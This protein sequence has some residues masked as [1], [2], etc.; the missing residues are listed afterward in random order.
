MSGDYSRKRFN[1][2]KHYQGVLRQ[3][4]RVDL[5]ADWNEY[6]DLQDRRWRAETIDVIGRC[7]VPSETPDGFKIEGTVNNLTVG[8][9]RI[10]VDGFLAENHGTN[11]QFNSTLEEKYGTAPIPVNDQPYGAGRSDG[12]GA[13]A[14]AGVSRCLAPRGHSSAGARLIEP[15]VNVDTTTRY[16]TAWQ[17]K[18]LAKIAADVTCKTPLTEIANWPAAN[19][20][21]AA[22]LTT[23]TVAV[24]HRARSLLG[25]AQRRLSRFGKSSLPRR[26]ARCYEQRP[27][28]S[29][30]WSRENAH[31]ATNVLEILPGRKGVRG[32]KPRTRRCLALQDRRLGGDH[33]RQPR[34]R[35]QARR[36]A[37]G[38]GRRYQSDADV[39]RRFADS[40]FPAGPA[41]AA[42]H[43]RVIRWDQSGSVRKP[44]GSELINLDLTNDGLILLTAANPSFVLEHGIQVTL[45]MTA[46]ARL[47]AATTGASPRAPPTPISSGSTR[48][49]RWGFIIIFASSRSS[50]RTDPSTIAGRCFRR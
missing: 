35:R 29:V 9:G 20:P 18:L 1:P 12:A 4:G 22:R 47:I 3:Q 23:T 27:R 32:R 14:F 7:G 25:A 41:D 40:D 10:Y 43:L 50:S 19:L 49:P 37:Q 13:T 17:V 46:V 38:H 34:V 5:D 8:Q 36:D 30:K 28:C 24:D 15:A 21:S 2:E 31:V 33:Q 45:S 26:G 16:Q 42:N 44:D 6:V 11:P 48:R 39:Q